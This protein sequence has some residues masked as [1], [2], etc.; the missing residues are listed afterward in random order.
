RPPQ[1]LF[2]E[3]GSAGTLAHC[4][5]SWQVQS[6]R[7]YDRNEKSKR[8]RGKEIFLPNEICCSSPVRGPLSVVREN[9]NPPL[10]RREN[11]AAISTST[12][13]GST[14]CIVTIITGTW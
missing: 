11:V 7:T 4:K 8:T 2:A 12:G 13:P 1:G 9:L 3:A 14:C 5:V 6:N 10:T